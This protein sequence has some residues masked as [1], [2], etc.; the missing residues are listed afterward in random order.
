MSFS[1]SDFVNHAPP[2]PDD[3][4]FTSSMDKATSSMNQAIIA[5]IIS[6]IVGTVAVV[7][8]AYFLIDCLK[9]A[10]TATSSYA[11]IAMDPSENPVPRAVPSLPWENS[12][13]A[14]EFK[15][16]TMERF[17]KS[18]RFSSEE[19][20]AFTGD[21]STVL[22][23]GAFGV[24]F[25]GYL[26]DG[27][28]VAVKVLTSAADKRAEDQFMA[29]VSSIGRTH[30]IYLVRLYGFCFD[31]TTRALVYEFMENGSLDKLL[32]GEGITLI[33][34]P[35]LREIAIGTAKG[36]AYLHE[37]CRERIVHYDIKPGNVLLDRNMVPKVADFGL[38]KLCNR[39]STHIVMTGFRGTPAYAAPELLKPFPVTFKCDVY[40]YGMLLFEIVGRRRNHVEANQPESRQWL[41]REKDRVE[42]ERMLRVA[43]LC[44]QYSPEVRP[45]M[46]TVVK[47]LEGDVDL[48]L[49][50]YPFEYLDPMR[51]YSGTREGSK[52]DTDDST[53]RTVYS[54]GS[55]SKPND[56]NTQEIELCTS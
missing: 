54:D 51:P 44:I 5:A 34:W 27:L 12:G 14:D 18:K 38:A 37:E 29:E 35:K 24:V 28:P 48:P 9:K 33:E 10:A 43:L 7:A 17:M 30:H 16:E 41:P 56:R 55:C 39:E 46:S 6:S 21:Y 19:L 15:L 1:Y 23:S 20:S 8:I 25:K 52:I 42:A 4:S 13:R 45:L 53:I 47:M 31:S 3:D 32:F 49:P 26:P 36:I 50:V 2:F 11:K 22:G 40:S